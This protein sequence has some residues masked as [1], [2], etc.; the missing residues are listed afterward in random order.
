MAEDFAKNC[1]RV[2]FILKSA[3]AV[4]AYGSLEHQLRWHLAPYAPLAE[5]QPD[6]AFGLV[7]NDA[8][9]YFIN[10]KYWTEPL[11]VIVYGL[12]TTG[13]GTF[14]HGPAGELAC[15]KVNPPRLQLTARLPFGC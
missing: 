2:C 5:K 10:R 1:L 6:S 14:A 11:L 9:R 7:C 3:S 13:P 12:L 4:R 8:A 15:C